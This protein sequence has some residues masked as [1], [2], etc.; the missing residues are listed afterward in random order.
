MSF[1]VHARIIIAGILGGT[2]CGAILPV[3]AALILFLVTIIVIVFL[4][5]ESKSP[6]NEILVPEQGTI[7]KVF[8]AGM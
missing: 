1:F 7:R 6:P 4:L 5:K 3:L 2:V 8:F